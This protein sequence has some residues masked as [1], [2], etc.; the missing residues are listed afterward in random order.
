MSNV[1]IR[2]SLILSAWSVMIMLLLLAA[3]S[4]LRLIS[5]LSRVADHS[6]IYVTGIIT[7]IND[8][9]WLI[10]LAVPISFHMSYA[11]MVWCD[12]RNIQKI[13][14]EE[15]IHWCKVTATI[16]A[17]VVIFWA[18]MA[19]MASKYAK[20]YFFTRVETLVIVAIAIV[21]IVTAN[22]SSIRSILFAVLFFFISMIF[23]ELGNL[24]LG[25]GVALII[26][27][28]VGIMLLH[29]RVRRQY[30]RDKGAV[31]LME[32]VILTVFISINYVAL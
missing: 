6:N 1:A 23:Y 29:Q 7:V 24:Q 13:G 9:W 14:Y 27:I 30:N 32:A 16:V 28:S 4:L 19:D 3:F 2:R 18:L 15:G 31:L 26:M 12:K 8:Y 25:R 11:A 10:L 5:D 17:L 22:I 20:V 21:F